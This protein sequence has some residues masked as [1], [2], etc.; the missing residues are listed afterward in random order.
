MNREDV[1]NEITKLLLQIKQDPNLSVSRDMDIC[2]SSFGL[3]VADVACF[4]LMLENKFHVDL[5]SIL[6]DIN[7]FTINEISDAVIHQQ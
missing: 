1:A 3:T 2:S 7:R 5:D 6:D 4:F